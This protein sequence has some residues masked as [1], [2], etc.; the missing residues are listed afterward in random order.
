MQYIKKGEATRLLTEEGARVRVGKKEL[1]PAESEMHAN[2]IACPVG[3]NCERNHRHETKW[4]LSGT[5]W[6]IALGSSVFVAWWSHCAL[7]LL[8]DSRTGRVCAKTVRDC[9]R[10]CSICSVVSQP[11]FSCR[12]LPSR[13]VQC[14]SWTPSHSI[15]APTTRAPGEA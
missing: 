13:A 12:S 7:S 15:L 9:G 3:R 1:P 11:C 6:H 10:L 2:K 8:G 4:W 14:R 5:E